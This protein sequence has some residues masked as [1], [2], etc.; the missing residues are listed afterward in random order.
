[1]SGFFVVDQIWLMVLS[2]WRMVIDV[3]H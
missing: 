1:M 3:L 2:T